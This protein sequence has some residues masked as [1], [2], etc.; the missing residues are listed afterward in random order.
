M[1]VSGSIAQNPRKDEY[2]FDFFDKLLTQFEADTQVKLSIISFSDSAVVNL[3]LDFYSVQEVE[4]A[5]GELI[6]VGEGT[7]ITAGL[8]AASGQINANDRVQERGSIRTV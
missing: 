5:V 3:P 1:D 4:E 7:N 8:E 2:T 6:W